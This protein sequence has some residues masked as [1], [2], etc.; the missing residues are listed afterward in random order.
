MS[1][2]FFDMH[3][4]NGVIPDTDGVDV[5]DA[6]SALRGCIASIE[7]GLADGVD[8]IVMKNE[9][10]EEIAWIKVSELRRIK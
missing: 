6:A 1:R 5:D 10:G 4:V 9:R 3:L 7:E 2:F 8:S